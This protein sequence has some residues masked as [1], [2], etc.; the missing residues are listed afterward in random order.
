MGWSRLMDTTPSETGLN[1]SPTYRLDTWRS[2]LGGSSTPAFAKTV[3]QVSRVVSSDETSVK[4]LSEV[5][6]QDASM[7]A[8]LLRIANSSLFNPQGR[9]IDT[10][11]SA[12]FMLGFDA[13]RE[14]SV[15]LALVDQVLKGRP[16]ARVTQSLARAFHAAAQ[17]RSF[18]RLQ[19][20]KCPEAVFVAALL[21]QVGELAFWSANGNEADEIERLVRTGMDAA[22]A[23]TQVLGF[24]LLELSRALAVDWGLG[25]LLT[26]ALDGKLTRDGRVSNIT[27]G[28]SIA[29]A[30]EV[31]GFESKESKALLKRLCA[32]LDQ[33]MNAVEALVRANLQDAL[34]VAR[35]YG[36]EALERVLPVMKPVAIAADLMG[37]TGDSLASPASQA[38]QIKALLVLAASLEAGAG[39]DQLMRLL[40]E[41]IHKN[42]GFD[43]TYFALFTADR[44][45]LQ[46]KYALGRDSAAFSGSRRNLLPTNDFFQLLFETGRAGRYHPGD[47][48]AS[49]HGVDWL[50]SRECLC[51]P[52]ALNGKPVGVLYGDRS[53]SLAAIS[54]D[55]V[56]LF[57]LFGLQ[58]PLVLTLARKSS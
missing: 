45:A 50:A 21:Y 41:G 51:M 39:L 52:I 32:H 58:I 49:E 5:I 18:A 12:V 42:I 4:D 48:K 16:H 46:A 29:Q 27:L 54:D 25:E 3:R 11:G 43:R 6:G 10:L 33:P 37:S 14:L 56:A 23:E 28:H 13:V 40:L 17:A 57:R 15:S 31:H 38:A 36:V 26:D 53:S 9:S 30:I 7:T 22:K 55:D 20:D 8:R 24:S 1:E 35:S 47:R 34:R 2:R 19:K 44:K